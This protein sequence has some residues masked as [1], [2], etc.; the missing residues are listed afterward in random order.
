MQLHDQTTDCFCQ[1]MGESIVG[2]AERL[3]AETDPAVI[4]R[5]SRC[6]KQTELNAEL[7]LWAGKYFEDTYDRMLST[8]DCPE[9]DDWRELFREHSLCFLN[10]AFHRFKFDFVIYC[11]RPYA[12]ISQALQNRLGPWLEEQQA[13]LRART[14]EERKRKFASPDADKEADPKL[15]AA[16]KLQVFRQSLQA[17][18]RIGKFDELGRFTEQVV[19]VTQNTLNLAR[20]FFQLNPHYTVQDLN[21][22][23]DACLK[24]PRCL[25]EQDPL[26]HARHGYK[27]SLLLNS[28][29]EVATQLNMLSQ[30]PPFTPLPV[31]EAE[32]QLQTNVNLGYPDYD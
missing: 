19:E 25:D 8:P 23:I 10:M 12:Q 13:N 27:I 3:I 15:S 17:R 24:L 20:R 32:A 18:N 2:V 29:T 21:Q 9:N 26:W 14:I 28:L 30:L 22:V 31:E 6:T 7:F 1:N 16:E 5:L 4:Y 11:G